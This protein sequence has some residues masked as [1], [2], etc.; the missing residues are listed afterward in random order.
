MMLKF[1]RLRAFPMDIARKWYPI[2]NDN[3]QVELFEEANDVHN[4]PQAILGVAVLSA[5]QRIIA[6]ENTNKI[7]SE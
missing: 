5:K 2:L 6:E 7:K 1:I 3:G 4:P